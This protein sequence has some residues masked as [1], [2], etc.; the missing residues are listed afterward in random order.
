MPGPEHGNTPTP[1]AQ[2]RYRIVVT[3]ISDK[4]GSPVDYYDS[5][6]GLE[7]HRNLEGVATEGGMAYLPGSLQTKKVT[8]RKP[9][10]EKSNTAFDIWCRKHLEDTGKIDPRQ[11][12]IFALNKQNKVVAQWTLEDA[13]P[14]GIEDPSFSARGHDAMLREGIHLVYRSIKK[15][16]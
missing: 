2:N 9:V 4:A 11:V 6:D 14:V 1:I 12:L 5:I 8:I 15:V 10:L 16:K 3:G 7:V 13:W